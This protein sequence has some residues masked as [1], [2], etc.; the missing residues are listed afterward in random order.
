LNDSSG[1]IDLKGWS[2]KN[3]K[4]QQIVFESLILPQGQNQTLK[5]SFFKLS[6]KNSDDQILLLDPAGNEID[7]IEWQKAPDGYVVL[8]VRNLIDGVGATVTRVIDGDT[9]VAE[10][11]GSLFTI[12]LIGVDTPET[13]HPFKAVEF[14]G[15]EAGN[16][17][18]NRLTGQPITLAFEPGKFD[19]YGRLLAYVYFGSDFINAELVAQGYGYAYTRFPFKYLPEFVGLQTQ[20]KTKQLGLWGNAVVSRLAESGVLESEEAAKDQ[21]PELEPELEPVIEPEVAQDCHSDFLKIDS[22]LPAPNKEGGGEFIRLKNIGTDSICLSRW[23]LDDEVGKGSKPFVITGGSIVPGGS[24]TFW[25]RETRLKLNN[26]NDCVALLDLAGNVADQIC[27]GKTH[28]GELFTHAGGDWQPKKRAAKRAVKR[29]VAKH[30]AP[31]SPAPLAPTLRQVGATSSVLSSSAPPETPNDMITF[32]ASL[33]PITGLNSL[34]VAMAQELLEL[35]QYPLP[36]ANFTLSPTPSVATTPL[37]N[38]TLPIA[39]STL[40]AFLV[41]AL[42]RKFL[43]G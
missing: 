11:K 32:S 7:S 28:A 43:G 25:Q 24:R 23:S 41:L 18:K 27:Y 31:A 10:V 4:G 37:P 35:S 34:D 3:A 21:K 15:K 19:K 40:S 16:Y 1:P 26:Q 13:V 42:L 9:I 14:Y 22:F 38:P 39:F 20:A 5:Q 6:L 2:L 29:A 30:V 12:R 17:L 36:S 8:N 33:K